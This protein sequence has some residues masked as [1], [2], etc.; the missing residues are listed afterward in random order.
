[1]REVGRAKVTLA[2]EGAIGV[3]LAAGALNLTLELPWW[4]GV[5]ERVVGV[6]LTIGTAGTMWFDFTE[7]GRTAFAAIHVKVFRDGGQSAVE[8]LAVPGRRRTPTA[9]N[10]MVQLG[11]RLK[12]RG[13]RAGSLQAFRRAAELGHRR[14]MLLVGAELAGDEQTY[15]EAELWLRKALENGKESAAWRLGRLLAATGRTDEGLRG[16]RPDRPGSRRR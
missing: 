1:M 4:E 11:N 7:R 13:D 5:I 6:L 14:S 8:G 3:A 9:A 15:E 16:S 10:R 12:E 2:A